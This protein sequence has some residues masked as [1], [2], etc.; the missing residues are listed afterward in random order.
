MINLQKVGNI[1]Y[2]LSKIYSPVTLSFG[3]L[4]TQNQWNEI[5]VNWKEFYKEENRSKVA[6]LILVDLAER[7]KDPFKNNYVEPEHF[8]DYTEDLETYRVKL[9]ET[10]DS[11]RYNRFSVKTFMNYTRLSEA[12]VTLKNRDFASYLS[13]IVF[14]EP[15]RITKEEM[16]LLVETYCYC[17]KYIATNLNKRFVNVEMLTKLGLSTE[18][19]K[20]KEQLLVCTELGELFPWKETEQGYLFWAKLYLEKSKS[21]PNEVYLYLNKLHPELKMKTKKE[22]VALNELAED[23]KG[24]F[25]AIVGTTAG[26]MRPVRTTATT[27]IATNW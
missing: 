18:V 19:N 10:L 2:S 25:Q 1:I 17:F 27:T 24:L 8:G 9:L 7:Y 13:D 12:T 16:R 3:R 15:T 23:T 22:E 14:L 21:F 4:A 6:E 20:L 26:G 11:Y 5:Q